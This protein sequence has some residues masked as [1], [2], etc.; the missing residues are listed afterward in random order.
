MM[1]LT[2]TV[3][4]SGLDRISAKATRDGS[5]RTRILKKWG[6]RFRAF[7]ER[8]FVK[9]SQGGGDW[10]PLKSKRRRG[11]KAR[12]AILRDTGTLLMALSPVLMKGRGAIEDT[13]GFSVTVGY[14]GPGAHP[15]GNGATIAE[16]ATYHHTG[17]GALPK[18]TVV[19]VPPSS[20]I[21]LM[22]QDAVKELYG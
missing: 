11:A 13:K 15:G 12:A 3:S 10:A 14:G 18:R 6:L 9:F 1:K 19:D 5:G 7:A 16:I 22:A 20:V 21:A 8:R 4:L 2:L 17:A